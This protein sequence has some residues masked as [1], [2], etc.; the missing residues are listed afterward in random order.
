MPP[1]TWSASRARRRG[2]W[3]AALVVAAILPRF[4]QAAEDPSAIEARLADS[5]RYLS[6]DELE[7]RGLGTN[8]LDLAAEYIG[9][10]FA[11]LG[12][13]TDLYEGVAFQRFKVPAGAKLGADNRLVLI[14]PAAD[15]TNKPQEIVLELGKDYT[16]LALSGSGTVDLPLVFAGYGISAT[17]QGYDDY[18]GIDAAGKAVVV[19]RHEPQ[20]DNPKSV[21][22]GTAPSEHAPFRRKLSNALEHKARAVL[23]CSDWFDLQ[24]RAAESG[25]AGQ[26]PQKP[27]ADPDP[28]LGFDAAGSDAPRRDL[29]VLYLRRAALDRVM[30]ASAGAELADLE[31]QIDQGPTPQSRSLPGWR[32]TG[33]VEVERTEAEVKNVVA[34]LPAE[35]PAHQETLVIGAHYDHL[36]WGPAGSLAPGARAIH[37]GADDNASGV[38]VL[39]EVAQHL[40]KRPKKPR[41]QVVFVAFAAEERGLLGSK[42]YVEHPLVPLDNTVAMINVDMVGRLRDQ[43]L[44]VGGAGTASGFGD[45]LDRINQTYQ[46]QLSKTPSG[47][48]PSDHTSFYAK[49]IPVL[50]FFTGTH[51]DYHRPTDDF[52]KLDIPNMRRIA[53]MV[54]EV[55]EAL[56]DGDGRPQY[57]AVPPKPAPAAQRPY[58]GSIP[59]LGFAGEGYAISGVVTGGPAERAGLKSGDVVLRFGDSKIANLDDFD[60]ALRKHAA[61]DRVQ[62]VVR[63]GKDEQAF[64]VILDPPR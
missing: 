34:L 45:L 3:L 30:R 43:K 17:K 58:F 6:S 64:Q 63:R 31:R 32:I 27:P 52:E 4:L 56:A 28:L 33:R 35:N 49:K 19:L 7:G 26:T 40:A 9:A 36:G 57:V 54:I 2:G 47:Y 44:I 61:G 1:R 14:G 22:N 13:K 16:P 62:T 24:K 11:K 23:F 29:P 5:A 21:F 39:I 15:P 37:N 8:G 55:A 38:A 20:Q 42:F 51:P 41:R 60:R 48:G 18:A 10:Q 46:F 12:L 59:D 25:S 50:H 53:Q